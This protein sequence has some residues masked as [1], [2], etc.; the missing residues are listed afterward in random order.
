MKV[1]VDQHVSGSFQAHLANGTGVDVKHA[2]DEGWS[3][4]DN[5]L[6]QEAAIAE[7]YTHLVSS[8]AK[9]LSPRSTPTS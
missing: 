2:S 9:K 4:L 7:G 5:G 8:F 6:L 1:L 3:D